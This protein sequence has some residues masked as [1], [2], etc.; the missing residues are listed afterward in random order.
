MVTSSPQVPPQE[1]ESQLSVELSHG[2]RQGPTC[3]TIGLVDFRDD[4]TIKGDVQ[5]PLNSWAARDVLEEVVSQAW[6]VTKP[7]V[8]VLPDL[9]V[10]EA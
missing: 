2:L 10:K 6:V 7:A 1:C 5:H 9:V 4:G 3:A 8:G